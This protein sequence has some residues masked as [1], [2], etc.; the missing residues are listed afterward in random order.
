MLEAETLDRIGKL[1]IYA[2]IVGIEL[3]LIAFEQR[4]LLLHVHQQG[5]DVPID[6]QLPMAVP[7]GLGLEIDPALAVAQL[8]FW[9]GHLFL[10][11]LASSA[12]LRGRYSSLRDD[13]ETADDRS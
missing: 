1:D 2:E 5:G 6:L 8:A 9:V 4:A 12:Q 11:K 7:R 10:P 3:E 13:P